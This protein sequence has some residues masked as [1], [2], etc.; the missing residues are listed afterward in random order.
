MTGLDIGRRF[1]AKPLRL[2]WPHCP[3]MSVGGE[4]GSGKSGLINSLLGAVAELPN[5]AI[6]GVDLKLVELWPWRDRLTVL[7]TT[8]DEADRLLV[9]LRN[10]IRDRARFLQ[11]NGHRKWED[12][13]G[14]WLLA[15]FDELAELQAL[16]ADTLADAV[17]SPD[18][19][20]AV[21]PIRPQ[22]PTGPHG[23]ARLAGSPGPVLRRDHRRRYPVPI[24]R[25]P[26]PANPHPAD[27]P[28]HAPSRLRRTGQRLPRPGLRLLDLAQIHRPIRAGR[29]LDRRTTGLGRT[30]PGPSPLGL[31]RRRRRPGRR[32]PPPDPELLGRLR[33]TRAPS[34]SRRPTSHALPSPE[35]QSPGRPASIGRHPR[36]GWAAFHAHGPHSRTPPEGHHRR[37][38]TRPTL[39]RRLTTPATNGVDPLVVAACCPLW[40]WRPSVPSPPGPSCRRSSVRCPQ[41][42][43]PDAAWS[44]WWPSW[45][46]ECRRLDGESVRAEGSGSD[47]PERSPTPRRRRPPR[48]SARSTTATAT[49]GATP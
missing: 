12:R 20:Q 30:H 31:R 2:P 19:A 44:W 29:P 25:G 41:S 21:A 34:P 4:T 32:H 27:H 24:G 33:R 45:C 7:A 5:V 23:P 28:G 35:P 37:R 42:P 48:L 13:F 8:P 3:H 10:L 46:T 43:W 26:R 11:A 22:R 38:S 9:D 1:D 6:C 49:E 15:A 16:D 17:E 39:L 40:P 18:T 14:P 47:G 36:R